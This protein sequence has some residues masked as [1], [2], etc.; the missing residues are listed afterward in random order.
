MS[1]DTRDM[2]HEAA[3]RIFAD[4]PGDLWAV[5]QESGFD[6]ALLPESKGGAGIS[7]ADAC[8]LL[9][10]AGEHAAA[11]PLAEAMVGHWLLDHAGVEGAGTPTIASSVRP[12]EIR[13][14]VGRDGKRVNGKLCRVP[15]GEACTHVAF[16][17]GAGTAAQLIVVARD[18]AGVSITPGRNLAGEPR[19]TLVLEGVVP[20][21]VVPAP[22]DARELLSLAAVL[23]SALMAG[24]I[25]RSL[26]LSVE[27]ANLR[28]QFGRPIGK[29]QAV[30]QNI[31]FLATQ[32]AAAR[33]AAEA[34]S[35]AIDEWLGGSGA[36]LTQSIAAASAKIRTGEAAGQACAIAHQVFGAIGFTEEHELH[37]F[38]KRLWSWRDECG[39]EAFWSHQL[40]QRILANDATQSL[41]HAMVPVAAPTSVPAAEEA[42]AAR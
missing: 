10:L 36:P 28:V 38:T 8:G 32:A 25:G 18:A 42:G 9:S 7:W 5:L 40:G 39:N 22:F 1:D 12:E 19:D 23:R 6:K 3:L 30:Q 15:W 4:K 26:A 21:A 16:I 31:A 35:D 20:Q 14:G 2:L 17:V 11:V 29:F 33:A 24:A 13:V 27:Y 41:W 37:R 34:G